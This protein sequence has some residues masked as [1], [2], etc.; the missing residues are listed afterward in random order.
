MSTEPT[1]LDTTSPI[2]GPTFC[3][4]HPSVETTLKC[5]KCGRYMCSRCAVRTP[6]GYR[7]KECVHQQ[8]DVY[9]TASQQDY[10]IA[11]VVSFALGLPIAWLVTNL[12]LFI[13]ILASLPAGGLISEAV[14]RATGRRR[15]RYMWAIV[16]AAI[17]I[18]A[19]AVVLYAV[20]QNAAAIN[21]VRGPNRSAIPFSVVLQA[22]AGEFIYVIVY[23]VLCAGAAASR[24]RYGK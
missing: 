24:L 13:I 1:N 18:S 15:G 8:Q 10:I 5:N 22:S 16:A 21:A 2:D 20:F 7:C 17:A 3:A 23:V 9:F 4:V 6:V 14:Q 19:L 11:G 12:G